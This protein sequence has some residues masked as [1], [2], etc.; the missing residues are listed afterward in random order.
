MAKARG[1]MVAL[2]ASRAKIVAPRVAMVLL[3]KYDGHHDEGASVEHGVPFRARS[4]RTNSRRRSKRK[5]ALRRD[6]GLR[7]FQKH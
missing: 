1:L 4:T 2:L 6:R 7:D 5:A 3:L